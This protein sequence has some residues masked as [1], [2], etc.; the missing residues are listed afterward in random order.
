MQVF[1]N[2][3]FISCEDNNRLFTHLVEDG[4]HIVFT[5]DGLPEPYRHADPVDLK[6]ACVL[7]AFGDTHMHF[8]SFAYFH[9]GLDCRH[10]RD[11][12]ELGDLIRNYST[13]RGGREKVIVGFGC[14][15][16][17]VK[18]R[19]LPTRKDLDAVTT[20]PLILVKYDG[21]AAVGNS[22]LIR[23][24]P[25]A[26][27]QKDEGFDTES[28]WF[29]L[30]SFYRAIN[31]ITKSVS[32]PR[33]FN[34]MIGGS[35]YLARHGIALV[36][37]TEGVG[38]PLDL[39]VDIMR[40]TSRGLPQTFRT[41]FQTMDVAKVLRRKLPRIGGC[42]ATALDGCFGSED[43]ALLQPYSNRSDNRGTLFYSQQQTTDFVTIANR[44][45]LQVA[46]HAIGDAAIEQALT[47]F[48]SALGDFPREDHRHIII[49]ADLMNPAMIEKAA[50]LGVCIALQAPFL[51]WEQEPVSYLQEILGDRINH[52]IPLKTMLQHGLTMAGGSDAPCT[53]PD[54]IAGIHAACNHPNPDESISVLDALR[55]HTGCCARLSFDERQRGTLS[56]GKVADLVVLDQNPLEIPTSRL[57]DMKIKALYLKGRAYEPGRGG[58][59]SLLADSIANR[60]PQ[61]VS[62]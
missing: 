37:T 22:A 15:A 32:I 26:A 44:N 4:G 16:H 59:L 62:H 45:G 11:F 3:A 1:K 12:E 49:H 60:Y 30:N 34:N 19:R 48:E 24:L 6:G 40:F 42:F 55:L 35:R 38:F 47:A 29:H 46:L 27:L 50:R 53:L 8:E 54:P 33:V 36:H 18:E 39:D 21:H 7:P 41:F 14:S 13:G 5:G 58:A 31:H 10:V 20:H 56:D 23:R 28:G 2:A 52:L 43:A 25:G 61:S 9:A 51:H 57:K 17:T